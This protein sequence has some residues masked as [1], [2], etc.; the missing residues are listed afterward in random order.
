ME[1][2]KKIPSRIESRRERGYKPQIDFR[3]GGLESPV[4]VDYTTGGAARQQGILDFIPTSKESAMTAREIA[5]LCGVHTRAVT[6]SVE[7][8]RRRGVPVLSDGAGFWLSS[9]AAEIQRFVRGM[10][11]RAAEIKKTAKAVKNGG[12]FYDE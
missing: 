4:N 12:I 3:R 11:K 8:A 10:E 5:A 6:K 9:D 7:S 1:E 2:S